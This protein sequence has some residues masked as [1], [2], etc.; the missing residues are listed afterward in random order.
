MTDFLRLLLHF[1]KKPWPKIVFGNSRKKNPIWSFFNKKTPVVLK[2][3][4]FSMKKPPNPSRSRKTPDLVKKPQE[5]ERWYR[6]TV[7]NPYNVCHACK[8]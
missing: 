6:C 3:P 2:K 8:L 4:Q 1:K 7:Y 5:W